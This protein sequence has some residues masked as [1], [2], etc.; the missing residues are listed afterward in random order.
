MGIL[1]IAVTIRAVVQLVHALRTGGVEAAIETLVGA[2][3]GV[4]TVAIAVPVAKVLVAILGLGLIALAGGAIA[5]S[6]VRD[7]I[8]TTLS[9]FLELQRNLNSLKLEEGLDKVRFTVEDEPTQWGIESIVTLTGLD[10][11]GNVLAEY[12]VF[13]NMTLVTSVMHPEFTATNAILQGW[14]RFAI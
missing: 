8:L 4:T 7:A 1:G 9:N 3:A 12:R 14:A 10:Q 2:G 5:Y 13:F 6:F 11:A